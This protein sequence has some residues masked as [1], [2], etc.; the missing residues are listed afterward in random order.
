MP[1]S[2]R[3]HLFI[4]YAS[5]DSDFAIWLSRKLIGYGY[6]VWCDRL[7]E[8]GGEP[9][10]TDIDEA[11]KNKTFRFLAIV[12]RKSNLKS[13]PVK[14]RTLAINL[15]KERGV[16]DFVIPL[17]LDGIPASEINWMINDL[18][19]ISFSNGWAMGLEQLL[20]K[21]DSIQTSKPITGGREL[22]AS[23]FL[24]T[25]YLNNQAENLYI[26]YVPFLKV[27]KSI[28]MFKADVTLDKKAEKSWAF[29]KV[30]RS[31]EGLVLAFCEPPSELVTEYY[32]TSVKNDDAELEFIRGIPTKNVISNLLLSIPRRAIGRR[33]ARSRFEVRG[34]S[35]TTD[36]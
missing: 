11:I 15:S 32:I 33:H 19:F 23:G 4:S 9:Y 13:N 27:P 21:L 1:D 30:S 16:K 7:K 3:D 26:N 8:L 14:E 31:D 34:R 2:F 20:K 29:F 5:E 22:I 18:T 36:A 24:N 12:S 17:N 10:P 25:E 28:K 6:A 35:R